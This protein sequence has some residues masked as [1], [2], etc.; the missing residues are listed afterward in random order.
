[1]GMALEESVDGLVKLEANGIT[2][3]VEATDDFVD[4]FRSS[5]D[6]SGMP[7]AKVVL[8]EYIIDQHG[9]TQTSRKLL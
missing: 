8:G 6:G 4:P 9:V 3:H 1:M 5:G 2:A 7:F